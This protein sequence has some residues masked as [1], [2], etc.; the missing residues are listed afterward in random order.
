MCWQE[1]TFRKQFCSTVFLIF[2]ILNCYHNNQ[3]CFYTLFSSQIEPCW[4]LLNSII[5]LAKKL[6]FDWVSV[7]FS[8][9][10]IRGHVTILV[11]IIVSP[12]VTTCEY[13]SSN[14]FFSSM[15]DFI[16]ILGHTTIVMH[17]LFFDRLTKFSNTLKFDHNQGKTSVH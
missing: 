1:M 4:D 13:S 12:R 6:K 17:H 8:L 9:H 11:M 5:E 16:V 7:W 10:D 14:D 15:Q 3:L 2:S